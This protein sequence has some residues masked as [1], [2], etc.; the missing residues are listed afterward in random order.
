MKTARSGSFSTARFIISRICG[1]AW[2]TRPSVPFPHRRGSNNSS[3]RGRGPGLRN[4]LNGIF[5]FAILDLRRDVLF[6][7]RDPIGVKP[8]FYAATQ[9][10]FIFG[11]EIKAI[12]ASSLIAAAMN[13]QAVSDFFT[14]LYVPGP[15]TAFEGIVAASP[16]A[17]AHCAAEAIFRSR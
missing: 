15:E 1:R 11:S 14:F 2:R 12:L 16:G 10:N 7:A 9:E 6:L 13:W 5:A 17:L 4:E 8:L 3:V